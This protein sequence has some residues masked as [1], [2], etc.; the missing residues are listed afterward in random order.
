MALAVNVMPVPACE[1]T[2]HKLNRCCEITCD[3]T[4][5]VVNRITSAEWHRG[6]EKGG[7]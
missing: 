3:F 6:M 1:C 2:F 4:C 5:C 7:E